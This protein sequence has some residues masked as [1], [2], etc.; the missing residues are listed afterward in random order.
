MALR[1][2][3]GL[4]SG[5]SADG[6]DAALVELEGAGLDVRLRQVQGLHQP[7]G[8]DLRDWI[9]RASGPAPCEVRQVSRLHRLLGETFAAAAR[10]VADHASLSLQKVQC[11]GCPGHT[12]WHDADGRFPS[13][14]TLGMPAVIA[15]RTGVT[16]VSDFRTR[17]VAAGGQGVPLT[18][19]GDHLL[20]RH[21]HRHRLLVHLGGVAWLV[22]LPGG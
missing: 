5:S 17:D 2:I 21:P 14:L 18:A 11:I 20:F 13:A 12:V 8:P 1:W 16:T 6:V 7:Y 19:L 15:E 22:Y 4:A 3:I 10:N 9:R